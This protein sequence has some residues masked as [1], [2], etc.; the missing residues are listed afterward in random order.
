MPPSWTVTHAERLAGRTVVFAVAGE[1]DMAA[2]GPLTDALIHLERGGADLVVLDLGA[3]TFLDRFGV[4]LIR[5]ARARAHAG[6]RALTVVAPPRPADRL[7]HVLDVGRDVH[8]VFT[9]PAWAVA[10]GDGAAATDVIAGWDPRRGG[11][12]P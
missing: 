1:I 5:E 6:R 11:T 2:Y 7:L 12:G 4:R 9:I 8:L 10:G 3:V